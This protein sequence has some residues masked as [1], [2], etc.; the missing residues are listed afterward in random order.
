MAMQAQRGF[1]QQDDDALERFSMLSTAYAS[2]RDPTV[3]SQWAQAGVAAGM[4][5]P[6]AAQKDFNNP[7]DLE[8]SAKAAQAFAQAFVQHGAGGNV[9]STYIDAQGNRVAIMRDGSTQVLGQNAPNNQILGIDNGQGGKDYFGVNKGTLQSLPVRSGGA[10]PYIDPSLPPEVQ[11]NIRANEPAYAALPDGASVDIGQQLRSAP[12]PQAPREPSDIERRLELA[13]QMG[14]TPEELKSLV[15]GSNGPRPMSDYQRAQMQQKLVKAKT[16]IRGTVSDLDRMAEMA[17]Q[18]MQAP[19]LERTT[20]IM[21]ALPN[22]PGS[23]A[24]DAEAKLNS[25]KSQIA[26]AVLAKMRAMSPTG[27]ALG[28][29]SDAEGKRLEANLA[30]LDKAQS[31]EQLRQNLQQII[32]YTNT[33]KQNIQSAFQD[34]FGEFQQGQQSAPQAAQS[35]G[36]VIRYDAQGNRI[37]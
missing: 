15:V 12:K 26:F 35:Q 32:D 25:L 16:S 9:Q 29:V 5:P 19:G 8:G 6:E 30:S 34:D 23:A 4:L 7:A 28:S 2:T 11:A 18:V 10:A 27:G 20:G 36:N 13:Q 37:K 3:A 17:R 21:G 31:Y 22:I 1:E 33:S 14:A 24:A